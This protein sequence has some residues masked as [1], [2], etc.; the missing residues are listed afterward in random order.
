MYQCNLKYDILTAILDELASTESFKQTWRL[1]IAWAYDSDCNGDM[2]T[3]LMKLHTA[4]QHRLQPVT[5]LCKRLSSS[6]VIT[7][8]RNLLQRKHSQVSPDC[9]ATLAA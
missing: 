5:H 6:Q 1:Q 3:H 9:G 2:Q 4:A 8:A 7:E